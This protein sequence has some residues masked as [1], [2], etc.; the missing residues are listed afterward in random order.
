[1]QEISAVQAVS[2]T[3]DDEEDNE[4]SISANYRTG[5]RKKHGGLRKINKNATLDM[6]AVLEP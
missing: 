3:S 6:G 4:Y 2:E 5:K 1:M